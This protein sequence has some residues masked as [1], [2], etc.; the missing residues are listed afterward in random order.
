[1]EGTD[2]NDPEAEVS[3]GC[4]MFIPRISAG[5]A[6]IPAAPGTQ[7]VLDTSVA[8]HNSWLGGTSCVPSRENQ[9]KSTA[10]EWAGLSRPPGG[11]EISGTFLWHEGDSTNYAPLF[12]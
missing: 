12:T 5:R 6:L 9:K 2:A 7:N 10:V 11:F 3:V 4:M 1:M 8:R